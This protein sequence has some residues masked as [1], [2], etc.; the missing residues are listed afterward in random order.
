MCHKF[1]CVHGQRLATPHSL[2]QCGGTM[3]ESN[4]WDPAVKSTCR[5]IKRNHQEEMQLRQH[6]MLLIPEASLERAKSIYWLVIGRRQIS[7][8]PNVSH[9]LTTS[10][11]LTLNEHTTS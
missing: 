9:K 4:L 10:V 5:W 3:P 8:L 7:S 6:K 2:E 11:S 1:N